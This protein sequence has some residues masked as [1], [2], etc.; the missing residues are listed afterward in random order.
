M[1]HSK[2]Y[3][4]EVRQRAVRTVFE[5]QGEYASQWAAIGWIAGKFGCTPETLRNWI[6]QAVRDR[7]LRDGQTHRRTRTRQGA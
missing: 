3:S 7:G 4:A 1:K 2:R 6:R 5:H